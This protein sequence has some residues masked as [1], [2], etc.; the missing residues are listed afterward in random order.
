MKITIILPAYNEEKTIEQSILKFNNE[1]PTTV[2][3]FVK[4][5]I[6]LV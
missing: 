6:C 4:T 1:L 2:D 5:E 3:P